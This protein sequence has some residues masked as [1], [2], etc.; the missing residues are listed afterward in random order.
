MKVLFTTFIF[1]MTQGQFRSSKENFNELLNFIKDDDLIE[2]KINKLIFLIKLLIKSSIIK[3]EKK[4]K[5]I[6]DI[7]ELKGQISFYNPNFIY[8]QISK[9]YK[10]AFISKTFLTQR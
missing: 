3:V 8:S 9:L 5:F 4:E 6:S 1:R 10:P 7:N 2:Q